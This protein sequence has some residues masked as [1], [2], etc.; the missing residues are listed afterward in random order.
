MNVPE[1][2]FTFDQINCVVFQ[3]VPFVHRSCSVFVTVYLTGCIWRIVFPPYDA[4]SGGVPVR[5]NDSLARL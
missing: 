5:T 1:R 4:V 2:K 3:S